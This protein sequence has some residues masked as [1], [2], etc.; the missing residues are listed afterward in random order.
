MDPVTVEVTLQPVEGAAS[1]AFAPLELDVAGVFG[2]ERPSLRVTVND[3]EFRS[4]V[5][6]SDV[7]HYI[8]LNRANCAKAGVGAGD[9]VAMTLQLVSHRHDV[10]PPDD[11]LLELGDVRSRWDAL[12]GARQESLVR[13]VADAANDDIRRRRIARIVEEVRG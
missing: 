8:P 3:H 7:G 11:L 10:T 2:E 1:S 13:W 9:T 12:P 6:V 5:V 4:A